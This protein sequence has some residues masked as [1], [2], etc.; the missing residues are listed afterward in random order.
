MLLPDEF[1]ANYVA[2]NTAVEIILGTGTAKC[3]SAFAQSTSS[4]YAKAMTA[5]S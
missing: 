4:S 2:S 1:L 5:S 3:T